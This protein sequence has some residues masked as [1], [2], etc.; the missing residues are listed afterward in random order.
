MVALSQAELRPHFTYLQQ[1]TGGQGRNRTVDTWIF[2]PVLYQLS[3]LA[4]L[5]WW[6]RQDSN[7]RPSARKADALPLSYAPTDT[8]I[9]YPIIQLYLFQVPY[10]YKTT[11]DSQLLLI[12]SIRALNNGC[13]LPTFVLSSG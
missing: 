13:G 10:S 9:D 1:K 3:Y 4:T 12:E 6:V 2:S 8:T 5:L 11:S 7:L